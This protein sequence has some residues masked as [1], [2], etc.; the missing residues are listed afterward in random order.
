MNGMLEV[1]ASQ[2]EGPRFSFFDAIGQ[3]LAVLVKGV[4]PPE[5]CQLWSH[6]VTNAREDWTPNF[7]GVQ[8]T[9]GRAWYTHLEED[10]SDLYFA[11][12]A[13]SDALVEATL[14]GMQQSMRDFGARLLRFAVMPRAS[15]C[16][17]G[18]HIFPSGGLVAKSGGEVHFDTEG[19]ENEH[20]GER[21][22]AFT[23]VAMLQKPA[24]GGELR[25]WDR[26][27]DGE[28]FP[29]P[30]S[31]LA[32][33]EVHYQVGSIAVIDSY[34]MHQIA[35]FAGEIDRISITMHVVLEADGWHAWF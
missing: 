29:K 20:L 5:K 4:L 26:L 17:P 2:I 19:L 33:A 34:R 9:F 11:R 16:G 10:R 3:H 14:P 15:W 18:V 13:S 25:V 28:L 8:F 24:S 31:S 22:P 32:M 23:I 12:A 7:G 6:S 30:A 27:F 1:N 35:P 21:R